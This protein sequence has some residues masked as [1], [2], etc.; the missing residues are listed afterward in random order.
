MTAPSL[1]GSLL[2]NPRLDRWIKFLPDRTVRV[3]TGK[4]EIGQGVVTALRQ[5]AADELDMPL[6]R[7]VVLSGDT[8][9][10]FPQA[11]P[12]TAENRRDYREMLVTA[13]DLHEG[14]SGVILSD[15]TFNQK[16]SDGNA[17]PLALHA[18]IEGRRRKAKYV[19]ITMCV[20]GG[21]GAAGLFEVT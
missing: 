11:V 20:G 6:E 1:P 5:I 9:I 12:A 3:A 10:L 17:F 21:M 7:V 18:L 13:P 19:V 4:V 2:D 8:E 14:I 15:E 16:L